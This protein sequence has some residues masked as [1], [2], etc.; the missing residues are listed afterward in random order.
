MTGTVAAACMALLWIG[1]VSEVAAADL[2][3]DTVAAF[4]RY[5]KVTE[6][7]ISEETAGRRPFL[8]MDRLAEPERREVAARLRRGEIVVDRLETRDAGRPINV[9]GGICHHWLGIVFAP[10]VG[11]DRVVTLMQSYDRY[12]DIYRPTIRRSRMTSRDGD[13]F[14][15]YLQLSMK[16]VI[17]VVLNTEYDVQYVPIPPNRMVVR[18]YA[19]RIAEVQH[20]DTPE[21]QERPVGHDSGFLWRFNNYCGLEEREGGTYIQCESISLS[22]DLPTGLGWLIRPFVTAI[23]KESLEFT[24]GRIRATLTNPR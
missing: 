13:R 21:E 10:D 16:K 22:R 24:L 4:D 8:W 18:S 17:S 3:A 23:P 2:R 20:P 11:L 5:V 14:N 6:M 12:S 7:R 9:P 19:T 1:P 15:V